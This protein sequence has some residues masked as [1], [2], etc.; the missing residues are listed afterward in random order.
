M[1]DINPKDF[2]AVVFDLGG[3]LIE[4]DFLRVLKRWAAHAGCDVKA[5]ANRFTF[6]HHYEK[7]E[8]GEYRAA[9]YFASLRDSLGININDAQF[10][11]GWNEVFVREVP[12]IRQI[13]ERYAAL[14]P[15]YV[16]SNSNEIHKATWMARYP[17]L[18]KPFEHVFVS[19]D[20]GK[21]K[22]EV[23]AYRQVAAAIGAEP[24]RILFFDDSEQNIEGARQAGLIG[25]KVDSAADVETVLKKLSA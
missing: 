11:K 7:H 22:P 12:N 21:R 13:V 3:V 19:S 20:M 6:D 5:I 25:L 18:L 24:Q 1:Q 9:E 8:R 4:I 16:F 2:D 23:D 10:L 17:D 15:V 14:Y